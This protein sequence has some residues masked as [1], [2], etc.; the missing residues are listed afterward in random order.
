AI[1]ASALMAPTASAA[2][3]SPKAVGY[4][5]TSKHTTTSGS[6]KCSDLA[7]FDRYRAKITCIDVRG[8]KSV[9]YGPW[10]GGLSGEWSTR[11]CPGTAGGAVSIYKAGYQV[12]LF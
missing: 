4:V 7:R 3:R 8:V 11:K 6:A 1:A 9:F 2:D 12:E 5:C 10:K